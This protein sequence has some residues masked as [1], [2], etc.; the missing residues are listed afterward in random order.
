M[1]KT[2]GYTSGGLGEGLHVR[3]VKCVV[4]E[5]LRKS[6]KQKIFTLSYF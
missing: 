1:A 6:V 5:I 2:L 3:T 4:Q